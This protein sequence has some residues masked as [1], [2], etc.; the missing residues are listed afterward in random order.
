[1]CIGSYAMGAGRRSLAG[2]DS[3]EPCGTMSHSPDEANS[4][5]YARVYD[6]RTEKIV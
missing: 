3:F 1:M 4:P 6:S 2:Q 5:G